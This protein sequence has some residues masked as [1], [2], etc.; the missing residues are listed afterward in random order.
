MIDHRCTHS[1]P[2][3]RP[4]TLGEAAVRPPKRALRGL[5]A[6][7][8][9][10]PDDDWLAAAV[11]AAIAGGATAVQ[12]RNKLA[13]ETMRMRQARLL[14]S[15][16]HER[17]VPLIVNDALDIALASGAAGVHL[18]RDDP[19]PVEARARLGSEAIIGV[20]CYDDFARAER[21]AGQADYLAFGSLFGSSVKPTAVRAPLQLLA[22]GAQRGWNLVGIGGIDAGNAGQ[23][24]GAGADAL[25]VITAVF[26]APGRPPAQIEAAAAALCKAIGEAF[27]SRAPTRL[28]AR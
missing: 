5:Y 14:A 9:D 23:A 7:T 20:S 11:A 22:Q 21:L 25:A 24:I 8:P 4:G 6:L 3:D 16:C 17:G 12:Y 18:G 10:C 28:H 15:L 19:D 13:D 26:G 1:L 27:E 2:E